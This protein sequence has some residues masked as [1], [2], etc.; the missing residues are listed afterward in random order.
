MA[1][2]N[3]TPLATGI[4]SGTLARGSLVKFD[5][6]GQ[7]ANTAKDS[8]YN[9]VGVMLEAGATGLPARYQVCRGTAQFIALTD[10]SAI[11]VGTLL[12]KQASGKVGAGSTGSTLVG[13]ALEANGSTDATLITVAPL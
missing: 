5:T 3:A 10:N 13:I 9:V 2:F 8:T 1:T 7:L 12:Y 11:T 4:A 6:N